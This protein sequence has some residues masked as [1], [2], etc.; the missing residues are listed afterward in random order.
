[1][2]IVKPINDKEKERELMDRLDAYKPKY[3]ILWLLGSKTGLR[4][5]DIL[6]LKLRHIKSELKVVESKTKKTRTLH[7]P[8]W[9]IE[10][11]ARYAARERIGR[12]DYVIPGR[13][14]AKPLTRVRAWQ[15]IS[16]E[17]FK[18]GLYEIGTHSMRK[19][20]AKNLLEATGGKIEAVQAELKHKYI[21]DTLRYLGK[22]MVIVDE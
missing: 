12:N 13:N 4:V 10:E 19:T 16:S 8:E 18:I 20:Y 17:A 15:V 21:Q 14:K 3:R 1:M 22:K 2:D 5:S 9:V 11:V 6:K 7:I